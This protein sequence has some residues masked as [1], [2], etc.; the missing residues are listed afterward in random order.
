MALTVRGVRTTAVEVPMT[1][2]LGTSAA[3]IRAAP[4]LLID[5]DTEE[6]TTGRAY[7]LAYRRAAAKAMAE[8]LRDAVE[9][10]KGERVAPVPLSLMLQ[11][12]FALLGVTGVVRMA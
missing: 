11:R 12:R 2:A 6:G 5:L 7:L 10:T 9:M 8:V 1:Y 3:T 4:L